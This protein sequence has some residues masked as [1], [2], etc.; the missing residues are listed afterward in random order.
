[1]SSTGVMEG[2]EIDKPSSKPK[3][4]IAWISNISVQYAIFDKAVR[5]ESVGFVK[6]ILVMKHA[7]ERA[8]IDRIQQRRLRGR[9][10]IC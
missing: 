4:D 10:T 1:M 5:I 7:P 3:Y 2:K 9:Y 6:D 8:L